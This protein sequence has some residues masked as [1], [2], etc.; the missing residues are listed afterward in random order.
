[1]SFSQRKILLSSSVVVVVGLIALAIWNSRASA[2]LERRQASLIEGIEK[3]SP[4]RIQ[5]LVAPGYADRWGFSRE[6]LVTAIVD[7]GSQFLVLEVGAEHPILSIEG[8][9]ATYESALS[10]EGKPIGPAGIEVMRRLNQ[11]KEPF[12]F[13]WEKQSFLPSSW[14][15]VE[16]RNAGLPEDLH[17]YRP[18]DLGRAMRGE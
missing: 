12:V 1:M 16:V 3:A 7:G 10:F 13:V 14:R 15:L 11:L 4:G 8:R 17:G 6:D 9:R 5:R 2:M 18:G